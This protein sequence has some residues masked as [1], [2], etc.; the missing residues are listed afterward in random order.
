MAIKYPGKSIYFNKTLSP[1]TKSN[2][3]GSEGT[4]G[5]IGLASGPGIEDPEH[6]PSDRGLLL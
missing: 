3:G 5:D 4:R 1:E 6:E 2:Q